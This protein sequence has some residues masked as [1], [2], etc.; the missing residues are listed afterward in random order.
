M[1]LSE[2]YKCFHL[3]ETDVIYLLFW[4]LINT[5]DE[6]RSRRGIPGQLWPILFSNHESHLDCGIIG[7]GLCPLSPTDCGVFGFACVTLLSF[8]R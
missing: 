3:K 5:A 4:A 7:R 2:S 6:I 1:S 8:N